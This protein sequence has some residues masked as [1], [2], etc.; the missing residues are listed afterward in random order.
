MA[1]KGFFVCRPIAICYLG[2]I[3][4]RGRGRK[5]R[6]FFFNPSF[7]TVNCVF[8]NYGMLHVIVGKYTILSYIRHNIN[9]YVFFFVFLLTET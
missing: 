1:D 2:L 5:S 6:L 9:F 8:L 7:C 4:C 3:N